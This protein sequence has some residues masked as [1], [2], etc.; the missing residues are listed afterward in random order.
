[1]RTAQKDLDQ[2]HQEILQ[3][4]EKNGEIRSESFA[5][6]R[7]ISIMTVRRDLQ[8]LEERGLLRRIHGGAVPAESAYASGEFPADVMKCREAISRY[9]AF[10]VKDGDRLFINGSRTALNL[11]KYLQDKTVTV[12]T[13]NGWAISEEFPPGVSL[14]LIGGEIHNRILVG[15]RTMRTILDLHAEKTFIGC[16]AVYDDG[17]FSYS[18][19]TEIGINEAMIGRTSEHLYILA[20]HT[21]LQF[22][23]AR[24]E[25]YGS[26]SYDRPL[27]LIT[28]N[29][30]NPKIVENLL[31]YGMEIIQVPVE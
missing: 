17:E 12:F 8:Q 23:E 26:C 16:A 2:R 29:K 30:V 11:L 13:N 27:T 24:D 4:L 9:A 7:G 10:F 20:D 31:R 6:E 21:K 5:R 28:D 3:I 1:M 25:V 18:I 15:D 22:S 14:R 19:P